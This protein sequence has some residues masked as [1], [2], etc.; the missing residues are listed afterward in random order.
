MAIIN[1]KDRSEILVT[2]LNSLEKNA[3]ISS[4]SPGSVARAFADAFSSEIS[5]LYDS[6]KYN[7]DQSNLS[8]ASGRSLDLI[9]EL[10]NVR[11]KSISASLAENR[12][13]ANIEFILQTPHS[14]NIIIPKGTIVYNDVGSFV[15][16]QYSYRLVQ[17]VSILAGVSRAYGIVEPNFQSNDYVAARGSLVRH[18][19]IGPPGVNISCVNTKE[20]YPIMNAESDDN[21][22]KRIAATI[23]VNS[24]GTNESIRFAALAVPGVRD[25]RIREA[26]FGLGSCD[27]I[28]VPETPASINAIPSA[29]SAAIARVKPAGIRMNIRIAEQVTLAVSATISLPYGTSAT[30]ASGVQNQA[31]VFVKRYLNSLTIGDTASAQEIERQIRLAS[32]L[33]RSVTITS[34]SA[35]GININRKDFRTSDERQYISSGEINISSVIIGISNY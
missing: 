14:G 24:S 17:D 34:M 25:V 2:I 28:V 7:I 12:A 21:Y 27:V 15:S 23:K 33:V 1:S 35:N 26:S 3:G 29:V 16:K 20:V 4:I 8:T 18:N 30:L 22:R 31:S 13:T 11:R 19:Y 32:D 9:G 6:F 10:Y 5:D